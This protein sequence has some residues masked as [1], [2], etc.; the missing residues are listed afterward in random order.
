MS[1]QTPYVGLWA[2]TFAENAI[3]LGGKTVLPN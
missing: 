1:S 2:L 3:F